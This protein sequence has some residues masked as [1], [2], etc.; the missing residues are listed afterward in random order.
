MT[1]LE[2][3]RAPV[4]QSPSEIFRER[5][6]ILE[7]SG[8]ISPLARQLTELTLAEIIEE[9]G[10]ELTEENAAPFVTHLATALTRLGR[11]E[12]EA[13]LSAVAEEEIASRPQERA[14]V[15]RLMKDCAKLLGRTVPD[16][17]VAYMTVHLCAILDEE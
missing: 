4:G 11:G 14:L 1:E 3:E 9:L 8:T 6:E 7:E 12:A 10:V 17:E 13:P 15:Q 2:P 16:T 5:L